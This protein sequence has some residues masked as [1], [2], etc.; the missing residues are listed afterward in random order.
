MKKNLLK[1]G[2][3]LNSLR[4]KKELSLR[5]VCKIVDYDSSN[6][7]KIERGRMSPPSDIETLKKWAETLG[8]SKGVKEYQE[9]LDEA[10][11]A[12]GIIPSDILSNKNAAEYLPAFFRTIR[13]KK[14]TKEELDNLIN[15]IK[16][17]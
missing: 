11:I 6:W 10:V 13:N 14:P 15:L 8:L 16:D 3:L 2:N 1:F 9:F 5:S 7:S 4:I 17:S 12:Q